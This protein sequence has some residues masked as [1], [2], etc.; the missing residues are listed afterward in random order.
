MTESPVLTV[1]I[2]ADT[3]VPDRYNQVSPDIVTFFKQEKVAAILHAGDISSPLVIEA[4]ER[5]APVQAVLGNRDWAFGHSLPLSRELVYSGVRVGLAHGHGG[6]KHYLVDKLRYIQ[7]GYQFE[8][9]RIL[10]SALFPTS[11][12]IVFGHTH[13]PEK[14]LVDGQVFFNP[15]AAY[16]CKENGF[17]VSAG[18]LRIFFDGHFDVDT[19]SLSN[20]PP[21]RAR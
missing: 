6:L 9:Y 21:P 18:L 3:H 7:A 2:I 14:R 20:T 5:I 19:H 1:G 11:N 13:R 15:G 10:L 16:P 4:L 17:N 8:R 12:V